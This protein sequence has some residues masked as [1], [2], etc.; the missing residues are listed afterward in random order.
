MVVSA[1]SINCFKNAYDRNDMG[2][3]NWRAANPSSF[4]YRNKSQV[5]KTQKCVDI[6]AYFWYDESPRPRTANWTPHSEVDGKFF[7]QMNRQNFWNAQ[8]QNQQGHHHNGDWAPRRPHILCS[9]C[10]HSFGA[11]VKNVRLH[12]QPMCFQ[13]CSIARPWA[14]T[15][16]P[17]DNG[18][19]ISYRFWVTWLA[20]KAFQS[21][22]PSSLDTMTNTVERQNEQEAQH[23]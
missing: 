2:N 16:T 18:G 22:H 9:I 20:S 11:L 15:S 3:Q 12:N 4:K 14:P 8:N 23:C 10:V 17:I 6:L 21:T 19:S 1:E 7:R 5:F 13:M